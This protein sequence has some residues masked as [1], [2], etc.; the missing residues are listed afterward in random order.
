MR[1][2]LEGF[3]VIRL[4]PADTPRSIKRN[5][6]HRKSYT[7]MEVPELGRRFVRFAGSGKCPLYNNCFTCPVEFADVCQGGDPIR[8]RSDD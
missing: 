1:N 4:M 7:E 5:P 6:V 2:V 8:D 3:S